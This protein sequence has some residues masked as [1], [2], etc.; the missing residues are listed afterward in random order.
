M[1]KFQQARQN[2]AII[3]VGSE[4]DLRTVGAFCLN[5]VGCKYEVFR[6]KDGIIEMV[7]SEFG[8]V[9][10]KTVVESFVELF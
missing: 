3:R 10:K 5:T 8:L 7:I 4:A 9:N 2:C 1:N 6:R